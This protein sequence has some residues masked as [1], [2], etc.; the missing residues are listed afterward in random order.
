MALASLKALES[1]AR[2]P[3][4]LQTCNIFKIPVDMADTMAIS[5]SVSIGLAY[6][7]LLALIN[8]VDLIHIGCLEVGFQSFFPGP[9][10]QGL[11]RSR[12][13]DLQRHDVLSDGEVLHLSS[14]GVARQLPFQCAVYASGEQ[15]Q[16]RPR[17]AQELHVPPGALRLGPAL[18]MVGTTVQLLTL[19]RG[20]PAASDALLARGLLRDDRLAIAL[21]PAGGRSQAHRY[22]VA[23]RGLS[24][25]QLQQGVL[26]QR[27]EELR[28]NGF[29]NFFE[30]PG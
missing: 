7:T 4:D 26:Q 8:V 24:L 16:L 1:E 5:P 12:A 25:Q 23:L 14:L 6:Y 17:L 3:R 22:T 19:P 13:R 10:L 30:P 29:P 27:M 28:E 21:A 11:L 15:R 18:H 20:L 9:R 2:R